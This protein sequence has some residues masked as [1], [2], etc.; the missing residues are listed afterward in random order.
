MNGMEVLEIKEKVETKPANVKEAIAAGWKT[1]EEMYITAGVCRDTFNKFLSDVR[2]SISEKQDSG[3]RIDPTANLVVKLG[4]SHKAY[5]H[6]K[7]EKAFQLY[8]MKNQA[9]WTS[10]K[11][12]MSNL[13][14]SS[15][16]IEQIINDLSCRRPAETQTHI[17]KGGYHN[18]E[19]FYDD[20]LVN[21]ITAELA[22]HNTNQN[23]GIIQKQMSTEAKE[24]GI[25]L[26]AVANSG[27]LKAAQALCNLIMEKT[28][29][30]A[31]NKRLLEQ[32]K[33]M[34]HA[35]E[36]DEVVGWKKWSELKKEL[37]QNFELLRHKINYTK[38]FDEVGLVEN[39]DYKRKVMGF[40]KFPTVLISPEAEDTLW[41][42][43]D[44]HH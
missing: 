44:G 35:L 27:D 12:L 19:V 23:T 7:V 4:S 37:A 32:T 15:D 39:E 24:Q 10:K 33:Q 22:K 16:T 25:L 11:E 41:D 40:D 1:A 17:K 6:P 21:M 2:K 42:W 34:E 43:L 20:Y 8:L 5:Y 36:Y 31:E 9:N 26:N 3:C 29:I 18:S 14:I 38:L 28:Q 13:Q 30:Q